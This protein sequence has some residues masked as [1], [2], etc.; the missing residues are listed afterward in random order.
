VIN[1]HA[2]KREHYPQIIK[3]SIDSFCKQNGIHHAHIPT[4]DD[5]DWKW[6][7][8]F[9]KSPRLAKKASEKWLAYKL[10]T[11]QENYLN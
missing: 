8:K 4:I 5:A 2:P 6:L 11:P 7:G 3:T 1:I 9:F 10:L